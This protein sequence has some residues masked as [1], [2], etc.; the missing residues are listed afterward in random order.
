MTTATV[1]ATDAAL[2]MTITIVVPPGLVKPVGWGHRLGRLLAQLRADG[3]DVQIT[4]PA[5]DEIDQVIALLRAELATIEGAEE[6]KIELED[7]IREVE[8]LNRLVR[9]TRQ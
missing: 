1:P 6:E 3:A 4:G 2:S 8:S 5:A 7:R 9:L